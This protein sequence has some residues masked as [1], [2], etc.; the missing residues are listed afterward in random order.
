MVK[1]N[2]E[3]LSAGWDH[4]DLDDAAGGLV[5]LQQAAS[6]YLLPLVLAIIGVV[7]IEVLVVMWLV[8]WMKVSTRPQCVKT[9]VVLGSGAHAKGACMQ[10]VHV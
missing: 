4:P 8:R 5:G 7:L 9:M 10:K 2:I 3:G 1:V 6:A